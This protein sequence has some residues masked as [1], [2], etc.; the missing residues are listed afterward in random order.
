MVVFLTNTT[1]QKSEAQDFFLHENGVTV[2]CPD[3]ANGDTGEVNGI[4][5]TKR[6][7]N[8]ITYENAETTCTSGIT[9]LSYKFAGANLNNPS[10][11]NGDI[12]SWDVSNVTDMRNLFPNAIYFDQDISSWDVSNVTNM[13]RMFTNALSFNQ[14][15]GSWDVSGVT[16]KVAMF[17]RA[18]SF[19]QDI[20]SWD[21][22]SVTDMSSMFNRAESFNQDIGGWNVTNVTSMSYMFTNAFSFNQ[23]IGSWNVSSVL[24]MR[25][26]FAG[27]SSFNQD[28]SFNQD[29][30]NWDVSNVLEMVGMFQNNISFN[31]NLSLW[32]V[33][34]IPT[35][36][37]NFAE[38]SSLTSDHLPVWGTCPTGTTVETAGQFPKVFSLT[39][40]YPNPFNPSTKISYQLPVNSAVRLEVFNMLGQRI[41]TLVNERQ[42][43][44][45][46]SATFDAS[47]VSSGVYLYRI[48]AGDFVETRQMVLVK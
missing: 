13:S 33:E 21:V 36:P 40:N 12:G 6:S 16:D 26:M 27:G 29:I 17:N 30:G 38:G 22:S 47:N 44:G 45:H 18:E 39:Q 41:A 23:D 31:Q 5:Y 28:V 2:L 48:L 1:V 35:A 25:Y 32:C 3:A 11:F 7:Y 4:V 20:S 9:D 15:I 24:N 14:N 42:N 34:Q 37:D 10:N 8:Q 46:H 19:N 43:A